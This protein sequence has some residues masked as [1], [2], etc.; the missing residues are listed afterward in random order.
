MV[1]F[2]GFEAQEQKSIR[3]SRAFHGVMFP[4]LKFRY[5]SVMSRMQTHVRRIV[6]TDTKFMRSSVKDMH[7]DVHR[8]RHDLETHVPEPFCFDMANRALRYS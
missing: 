2:Q 6:L 1:G 4:L 7:A 8:D 5:L 3:S